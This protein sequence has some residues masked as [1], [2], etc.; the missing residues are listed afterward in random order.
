MNERDIPAIM[1]LIPAE[2][3]VKVT[4]NQDTVPLVIKWEL[5]L[6]NQGLA[7]SFLKRQRLNSLSFGDHT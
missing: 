7:N 6:L 2:G 5:H 3:E 4:D 1:E